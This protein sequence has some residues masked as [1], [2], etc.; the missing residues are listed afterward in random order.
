MPRSTRIATS[1]GTLALGL[2]LLL[3]P[4]AARADDDSTAYS[5]L[6]GIGAVLCTL[7]YVPAKIAYAVGGTVISGLAYA[8]TV[9]DTAVSGPIFYSSVRGDYVVLPEHLEGRTK[10]EFVGPPY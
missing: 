8:W 6:A 4:P 7:V 5:G 1:L 9:G 10:L 2:V 3:T